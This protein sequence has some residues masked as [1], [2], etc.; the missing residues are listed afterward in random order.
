MN[1]TLTIYNCHN[2]RPLLVKEWN[3]LPVKQLLPNR[4]RAKLD[5][6]VDA[7]Y[8]I[9]YLEYEDTRTVIIDMRICLMRCDENAPTNK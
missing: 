8:T 5:N 7:K 9:S 2:H 4:Y 1:G 6:I 3:I